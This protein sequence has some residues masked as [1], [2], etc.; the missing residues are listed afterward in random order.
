MTL[1]PWIRL[2]PSPKTSPAA[3]V[4]YARVLVFTRRMACAPPI[5]GAREA[6]PVTRSAAW[7][8]KTAEAIEAAQLTLR[9]AWAPKGTGA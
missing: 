3:S 1:R 9:T 7:A 2:E 5:A 6:M 4:V 8:P